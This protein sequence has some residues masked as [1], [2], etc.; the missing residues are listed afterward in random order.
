MDDEYSHIQLGGV[1]FQ[2]KELAAWIFR[3]GLV[4]AMLW[5]SNTFVSKAV[6]ESDKRQQEERRELIL[7]SLTTINETLVRI[8]EKMKNDARQ[9]NHID[10]IENRLRVIEHNGR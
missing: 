5:A 7:K 1:Q 4:A 10:D 2:K 3:L 6:Y 9:D 8:D